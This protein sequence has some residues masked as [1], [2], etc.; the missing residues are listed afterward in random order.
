MTKFSDIDFN[1]TRNPITNDVS[2][3]IDDAAIKA[4]LRNLIL[5]DMGERPFNSKLGSSIRSLLFEPA[6]PIIASELESRIRNVIRNY[7]PRVVLL[8]VEVTLDN[9]A[10]SF[11]AL[12]GFR[13]R[14]DNRP[15]VVPVSL[16]RLR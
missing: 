13:L 8:R 2:I 16:K 15:L 7:E 6:N 14:D 5:T 4:S 9:D 11:N 1:F 10:N 3:L 12:I